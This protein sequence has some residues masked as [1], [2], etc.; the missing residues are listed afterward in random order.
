MVC[1]KTKVPRLSFFPVEGKKGFCF[2]KITTY[3]PQSKYQIVVE[4]I[5][6]EGEGELLRILD[7]RKKKLSKEG[8]F[9]ESKKKKYLFVPEE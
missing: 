9:D 3:S 5:E 2:R 6:L 7:E 4:N 8:F 1:W